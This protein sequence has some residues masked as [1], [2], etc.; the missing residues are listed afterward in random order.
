MDGPMAGM[1]DDLWAVSWVKQKAGML[2]MRMV[3]WW[4]MR[5]VEW[6]VW[7]RVDK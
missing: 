6:M 3:E 1:S 4:E 7:K 5:R 2:E